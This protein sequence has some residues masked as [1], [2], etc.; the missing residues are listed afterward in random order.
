MNSNEVRARFLDFFRSKG[1]TVVPSSPLVP[2]NDPTLLFTNAGMVQFKDVF[3]GQDKRPYVRAA[4]SQKCVRAG[5]KHND[6][7][8]VGYTARHHTFFEMLGN[9]SFGDYFKKDAIHYAWE[10][11][12]GKDWLGIDKSRLLV[13]VYAT[14]DEAYD[15]WKNEIGVPA[16]RIVRIGD[17]KGAK[18]A[19]DNFW[20]MGDTGPC[21]PCTEIFYDHD[22]DGSKGI[23][24]GPPGSPEE[25]GDRWIEIWNLVFMQFER[26]A[27][28]SMTELP[29]PSVDTGMGLERISALMQGSNDNYQTDTFRHLIG[30]VAR[31]AK[32]QPYESASQKVIADHIRAASFLITDGVLPSNEGRGYVLR[33]IMRRAIR[34]GYKLGLNEP[35]FYKLV[36]TLAE[37]MGSA[38]PELN[39]KRAQIEKAIRQEEDSFAVTLDKGMKLLD[40][41]IGK[42]K[43]KT[44]PGEVVFKLYDTYGFPLDLTAD[45]ARERELA[46]DLPGYEREME[47]Q[48][49]R[50]RAASSFKGGA[51]LAY[52]GADSCFVGYDGLVQE[53]ARVLALYRDGQAVNELKAGEAGAVVLDNT[54]FYATGGGQVG[55]KGRIVAATGGFEVEETQKLKG[56]VSGH[57]G[58]QKDGALKVGDAVRAAVTESLR[59]ASMRN[60]SAT[61][62]MHRAL[63]D[64]LGGHVAQKGSVVDEQRTRFD[65]SHGQ[66]VTAAEIAEIEDRV[67]RAILANVPVSAEVMK[68]DDAIKAGAMAL[69]GEKYGDEV[70]VLAMGDFSTELCGGTH[71]SRTG[72]IGLFKIVAEGGV[73]AGVRRVEAV[74]GENALAYLR[75]TEAKYKLALSYWKVASASLDDVQELVDKAKEERRLLE[76]EVIALKGKLAS[77]AGSDLAGQAREI[78]GV[79]V[80]VAR[81]DGVE[82][83]DLRTLLD[84][85]KNK[86]GSGIVLLGAASGEKVSLIAGVTNDLTGKVKAGE[87]VNFAAGQVG[88]KGGGKPDMAQAGGTQPQNLGPALDSAYAWVEQKL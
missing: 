80:L 17:N 85:L 12:T 33:R 10:F 35:F 81:V 67:N 52:D 78:K 75:E 61:H 57:F 68:Y 39:E 8:N 32:Q 72:D 26:S 7:E 50:A 54:P 62:L 5:G 13:T 47:A 3:T 19:S 43:D 18:F 31:L 63:R 6:L 29:A 51:T 66:P 15:L 27:D 77:S 24:G 79:K 20:S 44:I 58:R 14:D 69:F 9:F 65:F 56:A 45:I 4:S 70:R 55:D 42:L 21:G 84:Q 25:D 88:G 48:R 64:V 46:L 76:K 86:L 16:D 37:V 23:W 1:H 59:R 36:G 2:G 28:G 71:V 11:I 41:A 87:L 49:D 83:N 73:A 60:H 30:A 74:T 40:E 82:G 22:P 34:H 38:Y 53:G